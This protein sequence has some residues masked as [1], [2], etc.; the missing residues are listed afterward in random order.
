MIVD[1]IIIILIINYKIIRI[2]RELSMVN[3]CVK[4]RVCKHGFDTTRILIG[5]VLSDAHFDWLGE[6]MSVY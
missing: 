3:R 2:M 1:V 6:T 4:M 5:Y